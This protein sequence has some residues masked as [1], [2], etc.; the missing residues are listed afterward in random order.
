MRPVIQFI[1]A[2]MLCA[3]AP[4]ACAQLYKWVDETGGVNYGDWPPSGVKLQPMNRGTVSS[5]ADRALVGSPTRAPDASRSAPRTAGQASNVRIEVPPAD[6]YATT[7]DVN[8]VG[9][10]APYYGYPWR[11]A[12]AEAERRVANTPVVRPVL[13]IHPAIPDMPLPPRR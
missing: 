13:P 1:F 4:S 8:V 3:T 5:V 10:Y 7:G 9:A 12:T 2:C 6:A 11:P